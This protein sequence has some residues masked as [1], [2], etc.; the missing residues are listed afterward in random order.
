MRVGATDRDARRHTCVQSRPRRINRRPVSARRVLIYDRCGRSAMSPD[1]LTRPTTLEGRTDS[2]ASVTLALRTPRSS[3][4]PA[5]VPQRSQTSR[6]R[7]TDCNSATFSRS[8][9]LVTDTKPII[10]HCSVDQNCMAPAAPLNFNFNDLHAKLQQQR[11]LLA[12][13]PSL[14]LPD[15]EPRT[16]IQSRK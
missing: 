16:R 3:G 13:F 1:W 7:P 4:R 12:R 6:V 15:K 9:Y 11:E 10:A 2:L 5:S 14:Q 8:S